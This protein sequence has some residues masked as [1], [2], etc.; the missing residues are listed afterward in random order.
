MAIQRYDIDEY[1]VHLFFSLA[2]LLAVLILQF[3]QL[4]LKGRGKDN[5]G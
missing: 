3:T 2:L 4:D 5:N 1:E